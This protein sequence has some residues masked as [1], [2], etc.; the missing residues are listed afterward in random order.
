MYCKLKE[1]HERNG[2]C[3]VPSSSSL[4][5]WVV[6]QRFLF[7]RSGLT[8][9]RVSALNML[10]FTWQTRAEMIWNKRMNELREYKE[11]NGHVIVPTNYPPN[12]QLS[13]WVSSQRRKY[14]NSKLSLSRIEE[15][16]E[17][18]F[19]WRVELPSWPD[20]NELEQNNNNVAR[21]K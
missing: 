11:A 3:R 20:E 5:Q 1:F 6:R 21:R 13:S 19:A 4:G 17:I 16:E 2:H 12:I 7:R 14:K 8:N 10:N 15:L 18:G 9:E